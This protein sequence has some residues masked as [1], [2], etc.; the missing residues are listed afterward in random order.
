MAE[1]KLAPTYGVT[2]SDF[3]DQY[4]YLGSD[5]ILWNWANAPIDTPFGDESAVHLPLP[6]GYVVT[7]GR[8]SQP[9]RVFNPDNGLPTGV[10]DLSDARTAVPVTAG[11]AMEDKIQVL[12]RA[13][14]PV[15]PK[16][17]RNAGLPEDRILETVAY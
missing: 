11:S 2:E 15:E 16:E 17:F 6:E 1:T 5:E 7:G 13:M 3:G 4:C 14:E 12:T 10:E 9:T 8:G